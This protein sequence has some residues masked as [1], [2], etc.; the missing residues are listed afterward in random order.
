VTARISG[1]RLQL[2]NSAVDDRQTV[3]RWNR[4][5]PIG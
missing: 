2:V 5:A 3:G 4:E 1:V